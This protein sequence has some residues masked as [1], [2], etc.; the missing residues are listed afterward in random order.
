MIMVKGMDIN[1][2]II[3]LYVYNVRFYGTLRDTDDWLV[4]HWRRHEFQPY[5]QITE[6]ARQHETTR[7]NYLCYLYTYSRF[8][9][10]ISEYVPIKR[11]TRERNSVYLIITYRSNKTISFFF[12][13]VNLILRPHV[14][15]NTHTTHL[16]HAQTHTH[17][18]DFF[19]RRK[20]VL[21]HDSHGSQVDPLTCNDHN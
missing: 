16:S 3:V 19:F 11:N 2:G 15:R 9:F 5:H 1:S 7:R 8:A 13:V 20:S 21:S 10:L 14:H 18:Q 4:L 12:V 17:I 6:G